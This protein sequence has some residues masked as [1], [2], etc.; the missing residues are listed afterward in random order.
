MYT[1]YIWFWPTL[2]IIII[3]QCNAMAGQ[4]SWPGRYCPMLRFERLSKNNA[5][6]ARTVI[7]LIASNCS[8]SA[9]YIS[10]AATLLCIC[11]LLRLCCVHFA[12][13]DS[14]VYI[15]PIATLLCICRLLR[16]CCVY[17]AYRDSAVY[18]SPIATLLCIFRLSRLCC[19]YFAYCDSAVYISP[20]ATL[21]RLNCCDSAV[22]ISTAA[23]LL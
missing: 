4:A 1:V 17:F 7:G 18:I 15:S 16:L 23:T 22:Y 6:I 9:V 20:I 8:E 12:Y 21:L 11:R 5:F 10:T 19:V 3:Q 13:C 2:Y 14:A